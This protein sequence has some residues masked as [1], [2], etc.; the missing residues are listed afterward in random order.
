M[1]NM[2]AGNLDV[3]TK[4][5]ATCMRRCQ[6][7]ITQAAVGATSSAVKRFLQTD[8]KVMVF[9]NELSIK[10]RMKNISAANFRRCDKISRHMHAKQ[11][12][13]Y[14]LGN[15]MATSFSKFIF[16]YLKYV[17]NLYNVHFIYSKYFLQNTS[18]SNSV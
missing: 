17:Q 8:H 18:G 7:V 10:N 14:N 12:K 16:I 15:P 6:N 5:H 13:S 1:K 2:S 11:Q 9:I 3:V 4:F